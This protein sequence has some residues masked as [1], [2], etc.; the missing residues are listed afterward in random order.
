[1]G[2]W[3]IIDRAN[4][5]CQTLARRALYS[6]WW[7]CGPTAASATGLSTAAVLRDAP[8]QLPD[9]APSGA[10][11]PDTAHPQA[12]PTTFQDCNFAY[13][14]EIKEASLLL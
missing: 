6:M 10:V 12:V 11:F 9:Y 14:R 4:C 2:V 13:V 7:P 5:P 1:M 8:K 3:T